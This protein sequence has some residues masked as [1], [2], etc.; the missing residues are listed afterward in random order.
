MG[1]G[2]FSLYLIYYYIFLSFIC[3]VGSV[4]DSSPRSTTLKR[5]MKVIGL[6]RTFTSE[7][8]RMV[9]YRVTLVQKLY[10]I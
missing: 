6:S 7:S 2:P 8:Q 4:H 5:E 3:H 10:I 1:D 9:F